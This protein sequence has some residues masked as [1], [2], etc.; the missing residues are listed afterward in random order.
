VRFCPLANNLQLH[1]AEDFHLALDRFVVDEQSSR[2]RLL[3]QRV[4]QQAPALGMML[5]CFLFS[6][7]ICGKVWLI[8]GMGLSGFCFGLASLHDPPRRNATALAHAER[9][10]S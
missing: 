1:A 10:R 4:R 2:V 6:T 8:R 3:C 7:A 9:F 5:Q